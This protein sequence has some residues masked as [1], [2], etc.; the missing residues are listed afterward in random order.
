M[1]LGVK[2]RFFVSLGSIFYQPS[3]KIPVLLTSV[4]EKGVN[5][6]IQTPTGW[7]HKI[8]RSQ[9]DTKEKIKIFETYPEQILELLVFI[10]LINMRDFV[11]GIT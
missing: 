4:I 5:R 1:F 7:S 6:S 9:R 11:M 10:M 3:G 8:S 2:R